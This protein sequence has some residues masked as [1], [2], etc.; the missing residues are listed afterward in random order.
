MG[1]MS[2]QAMLARWQSQAEISENI[3]EWRLLEAR[4][5][6]TLPL[7]EDL[8]PA[9]FASLE[10]QGIHSL[11]THQRQAW[12]A[13][14]A[15]RHIVLATGTASGKTLAYNLPVLDE[16]L[17]DPAACALYIFPT[18][19][20]AQDQLQIV[21]NLLLPSPSPTRGREAGVRENLLPAIY[22]GDTPANHRQAVRAEARLVFTN[23]DMLH[24]GI[25]PH[26]TGWMRFLSSLKYVVID[27]MHT[28]RGVFGS[29]VAN[30]LRRLR[31]A[32]GF[33]GARPL[34]ILTSAT[35]ANPLELAGLLVEAP[36]HLIDQ[37]GSGRGQK[38]FLIYNPPILDEQLGIRRGLIPESTRLAEDLITY[39][40]Q[41]ILF[42]RTRRSVEII[43]AYLQGL[44][45]SCTGLI[46]S[47]PLFTDTCLSRWPFW[48]GSA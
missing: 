8:H 17:R 39:D 41:S 46:T 25:L 32:A 45:W 6:E 42:S 23:P 5:P 34:F 4:P 33:Y 3:L 18:K 19:A 11:Y 10:A 47:N 37:D 13:V 24:T 14:Q 22:D 38:H 27:E 36:V 40:V 7:P 9:L 12:E 31:R 28:Y 35:I 21:Q 15:G 43:L 1:V 30:V 48:P 26:H 29:H 44:A 20:L 2:L 16:L